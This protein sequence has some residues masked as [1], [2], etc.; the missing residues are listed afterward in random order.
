[1]ATETSQDLEE[2][3]SGPEAEDSIESA[4]EAGETEVGRMM[5]CTVAIGFILKDK[6]IRNI[7]IWLS[8][9]LLSASQLT[10]FLQGTEPQKNSHSNLGGQG[11]R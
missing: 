3:F 9:V 6:Q 1:M 10:N 4:H 8:R 7:I 2:H 5:R 11:S